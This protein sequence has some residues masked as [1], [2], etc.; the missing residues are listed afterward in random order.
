M[1]E[2]VESNNEVDVIVAVVVPVEVENIIL[3]EVASSLPIIVG[4]EIDLVKSE[5]DDPV[6]F[7]I[8]VNAELLVVDAVAEEYPMI[9]VL[10]EAGA[11]AVDT[12]LKA[13]EVIYVEERMDDVE[14]STE[15]LMVALG[16]ASVLDPSFVFDTLCANV[17]PV[18]RI[19]D[20]DKKT[21]A[22]SF[23]VTDIVGLEV[24]S[25]ELPDCVGTR[26]VV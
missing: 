7:G 9:V 24:G 22:D 10:K 21:V 2:D 8:D 3:D 25:V 16:A 14:L 12:A 20:D 17:E 6:G 5:H 23:R 4:V 19:C 26:N 13:V 1:S 11:L 18:I 15:V